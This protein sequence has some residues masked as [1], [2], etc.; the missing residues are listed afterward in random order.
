MPQCGRCAGRDFAPVWLTRAPRLRDDDGM[1]ET[2]MSF[3]EPM[4]ASANVII[5]TLARDATMVLRPQEACQIRCRAGVLWVT[6]QGDGRDFFLRPG[7]WLVC[8]A[9][10]TAVLE[11]RSSTARFTIN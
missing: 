1:A 3:V 11:A 6:L 2:V 7:E 9:R 5:H 8:A 4:P 10:C